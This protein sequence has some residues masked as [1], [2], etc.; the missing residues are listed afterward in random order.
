MRSTKDFTS[1]FRG[2]S[3]FAVLLGMSLASLAGGPDFRAEDELDFGCP[4]LS[5]SLRK[6]GRQ[7]RIALAL[8]RRSR[9]E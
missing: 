3:V 9:E 6:G 5:R 1:F 2:S 4:T 8:R 7:S